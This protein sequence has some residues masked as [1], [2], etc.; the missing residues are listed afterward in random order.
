MKRE[1]KHGLVTLALRGISLVALVGTVSGAT[2]CQGEGVATE[3][4]EAQCPASAGTIIF[5]NDTGQAIR[6]LQ[7]RSLD[8]QQTESLVDPQYPLP[9]GAE[10]SWVDC[11]GG[12]RALVVTLVDGTQEQNELPALDP[13]TNR[14]RMNARGITIEPPPAPKAPSGRDLGGD[15]GNGSVQ[16]RR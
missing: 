9:A 1:T 8:G 14:L 10:V 15:P 13:S 5:A 2:G 12:S 7:I 11:F 6:D 16:P 4:D 3:Y